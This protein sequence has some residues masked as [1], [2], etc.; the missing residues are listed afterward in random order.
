MAEVVFHARAA[1]DLEEIVRYLLERA[2]SKSA[3]VVRRHLL[4]RAARL[5]A[6]VQLGVRSSHASI[7]ILSP[8]KYPYRFYFTRTS[9]RVVIL[10]I[11]HTARELPDDLAKLLADQ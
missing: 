5:G 4:A 7:Q 6:Q 2:G 8:A 3:D 1:G 11:R 9:D 10:H